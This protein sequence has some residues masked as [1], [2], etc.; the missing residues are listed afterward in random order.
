M[1]VQLF[2]YKQHDSRHDQITSRA[3]QQLVMDIRAK[4]SWQGGCAMNNIKNTF[5]YVVLMVILDG[6][7]KRQYLYQV[8]SAVA[9]DGS[10]FIATRCNK[11]L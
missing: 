3:T 11:S 7:N 2:D 8:I 5:N 1:S 9:L 4:V 6:Q 10:I